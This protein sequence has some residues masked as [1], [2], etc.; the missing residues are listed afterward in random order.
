MM[1]PSAQIFLKDARATASELS[2][3]HV[4]A[5]ASRLASHADDASFGSIASP[6]CLMLG[7]YK[8]WV[9]MTWGVITVVVVD[10]LSQPSPE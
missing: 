3:G 8:N 9:D 5:L 7:I 4:S 10:H 1:Q 2:R 6:S